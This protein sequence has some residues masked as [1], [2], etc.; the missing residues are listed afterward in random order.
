MGT[1]LSVTFPMGRY[2]ATRWDGGANTSDVEWPPSPWRILR[3]LIAVWHTRWPDLPA[4]EFDAVLER[5]GAP[6]AYWTPEVSP[7]S[8]RHY[9]P[10][11]AHSTATT[12]NTDQVLDA[13][14]AVPPAQQLL[15]RW[16]CDLTLEERSVLGKLTELM[17]YL[18][19]SESVC[20]A[21]LVERD[22]TP[23]ATWWRLGE[24]GPDVERVELLS[25]D[26]PN[27]RDLLEATT[28]QT[29]RARRLIPLGS[30]RVTYGRSCPEPAMPVAIDE[31]RIECLR[32]ELSSQV[33]VRARNAVLAADAMHGLITGALSRAGYDVARVVGS[34]GNGG[35]RQSDHDHVHIVAISR[36]H[37]PVL[38]HDTIG[39]LLVWM[40]SP[41]SDSV[42]GA[43]ANAAFTLDTREDLSD[44]MAT[45]R[46][47]AAGAGRVDHIAPDLVGPSRSW[48]SAMPY[49]PVRHRK[50]NQSDEDFLGQDIEF[51][52]RYRGL[53]APGH[54]DRIQGRDVAGQIA[55]F[56]RYRSNE[57]L[58]HQRR[59]VYLRLHFAEAVN[60]P[61]LLGQLS[62][63]GFGL[64]IPEGDGG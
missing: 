50:K 44:G 5:L 51:E 16:D 55:Q 15:I 41:M 42:A 48:I 12:G 54:I 63:F 14:L 57:H 56:R 11:V 9:M 24:S 1:T 20:E 19:R 45:Q 8:T 4:A 21:S 58:V 37:S 13:F 60:G 62:H 39:A 59:G 30:R 49:L 35:G 26:G 36:S 22:R 46:L 17:P 28:V 53:T 3:A 40:P 33:P 23:N 6:S 27:R 25:P 29:R 34:D 52:C 61:L 2:H 64:F 10:D 47:L 31:A 7:G 38:A 43:I 32:F 18:G